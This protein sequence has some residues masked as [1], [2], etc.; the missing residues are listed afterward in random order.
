MKKVF[1]FAMLSLIASGSLFAQIEK[2]KINIAAGPSMHGTGDLKGFMVAVMYEHQFTK[3]SSLSNGL[4]T[5]IH[6]GKEFVGLVPDNRSLN[7]TTAGIQF[8]SVASYHLLAKQDTKLSAYAGALLRFQSTSL[9]SAYGYT[10]DPRVYP[11]PFYV[12]YNNENANT[13]SPGYGFGLSLKTRI[14]PK[15]F[16]GITA[17]FQNDTRGDAITAISLSFERVL[18]AH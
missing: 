17:G 9:P 1:C 18:S 12:V 2:D 15:Y 10:Q 11:E 5:T 14:A 3:R 6:Y 4:T 8:N 13:I 16:L 7:F